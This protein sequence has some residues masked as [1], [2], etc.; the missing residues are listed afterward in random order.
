MLAADT[1]PLITPRVKKY[2][3]TAG[4]FDDAAWRAWQIHWFTTGLQAFEQ[5]LAGEP[6]TGRFCHGDAPTMADICLASILVV[7]RIFKIE[8]ADIPTAQRIM[9]TCEQLDAFGKA[10]P[11][12]Q[13]GAPQA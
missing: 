2:L 5:R 11:S 12:R 6:S 8:V 13:A 4:R 1:H 10:D 3:T 7:M 9:A